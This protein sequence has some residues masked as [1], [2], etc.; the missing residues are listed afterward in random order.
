MAE[1]DF[2]H[3]LSD[4]RINTVLA[5][6]IA[7]IIFLSAVESAVTGDY[8]WTVFATAV[9]TIV[10]LPPLMLRTVRA[11]PPWEVTLLASLPVVGRAVATFHLTSDVATYLSIAALALL[12]AVDLHL[13]TPVEMTVSFAILFVVITTLATA[14]VWAVV[15]WGFDVWLGTELL[16]EPDLSEAEIE[17]ELMWEFVASTVAGLVAGLVFEFYVRRRSS[18]DFRLPEGSP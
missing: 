5:W 2:G 18:I 8:L 17:E 6:L 7:G 4:G 9:V 10:V 14:G 12:I 3:V 15:R 11:M 1:R 16:F 13:F